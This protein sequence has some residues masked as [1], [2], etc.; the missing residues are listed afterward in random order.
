MKSDNLSVYIQ[1]FLQAYL[2]LQKGFSRNTV[3]SYRDTIK[4][5]LVFSAARKKKSVTRL[6][7]SDLTPS[8]VTEFL[9]YLEK[10]AW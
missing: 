7:V 8:M 9:D 3:L 5:F 2:T 4:L 10:K 6:I 1:N